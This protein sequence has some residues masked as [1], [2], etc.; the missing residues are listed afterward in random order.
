MSNATFRYREIPAAAAFFTFANYLLYWPIFNRAGSTV[1]QP[2]AHQVTVDVEL[3]LWILATVARNLV[4]RPLDL[5]AGRALY[6][7]PQ[8]IVHSEHLL[9][10]QVTFAPLFLVTGN[11]VLAQQ[12]TLLLN[13]AMCG[14]AL[15]LLL[16]HWRASIPAAIF[17]GLVYAAFPARYFSVFAPNTS[18]VQYLPLALLFLDRAWNGGRARD[19]FL[20]GIFLA[21]QMLTSFYLAY[22]TAFFVASYALGALLTR[23][24][25]APRSSFTIGVAGLSAVAVLL[26]VSFPYLGQ[27][28]SKGFPEHETRLLVLASNLG[29]KNY[30][31]SPIA[32]RLW[33]WP[34]LGLEYYVGLVPFALAVAGTVAAVRAWRTIP[35]AGIVLASLMSYL[36]A[37]G[38]PTTPD[39]LFWGRPFEWASNWMPGFSVLRAPGR[40]GMGVLLGVAALAGLGADALFGALSARGFGRRSIAVGALALATLTA[41]EFGVFH[42]RFGSFPLPVGHRIPRVY[43]ALRDAAPGPVLELPGGT[44]EPFVYARSEARYAYYGI[45]HGHELLNGYTGYLPETYWLVMSVAR[46]LPEPRA[47]DLLVRLTGLRYVIVHDRAMLAADR[48]AWSDPAGLELIARYGDDRL[49][50]VPAAPANLLPKLLEPSDDSRTLLGN[51]AEPL[52]P[53]AMQ[54]DITL[55]EPLPFGDDAPLFAG[56]S[57]MQL[58]LSVTNRSDRTWPAT[59][60][61]RGSRVDWH[62]YWQAADGSGERIQEQSRPIG[63]D[64]APGATITTTLIGPTPRSGTYDLVI[65]LSQGDKMFPN[66]SRIEGVEV[67]SRRLRD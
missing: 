2:F 45:Y 55:P 7:D 50:R 32:L 49:F 36:L 42:F 37:M 54:A 20:F 6:P 17:G 57:G 31:L 26:A 40:F 48:E 15:Y 8:P 34:L 29:W 64:L 23:G 43:Q 14:L 44:L 66:P 58:R 28:D 18:A 3:I 53:T 1:F 22:V 16:R 24:A 61:D 46:V 9:S 60:L 25:P 39:A 30:L 5:M 13:M 4:T 62:W 63:I 27:M 38:P 33:K 59:T 52:P 10:Q 12:L 51:A 21:L 67:R 19:G 56:M 11:P 65:G 41:L 47:L 35:V